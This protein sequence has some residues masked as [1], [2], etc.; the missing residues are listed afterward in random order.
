LSGTNLFLAASF[1][2]T[3]SFD[4]PTDVPPQFTGAQIIVP[5]PIN[6]VLYLKLRDDPE[7]VQTLALPVTPVLQSAPAAVAV[8]PP[9]TVPAP[10][11]ATA[12]P[13]PA[14]SPSAETPADKPAPAPPGPAVPAAAPAA[15]AVPTKDTSSPSGSGDRS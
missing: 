12:P 11:S 13:A 5:H 8:K 6:G 3:P 10:T 9:P 4:N 14:A 7:T 1:A 15:P 2:D